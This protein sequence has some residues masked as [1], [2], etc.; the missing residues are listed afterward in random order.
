MDMQMPDHPTEAA[1]PSPACMTAFLKILAATMPH[2]E[3]EAPEDTNQRWIAMR[4]SFVAFNP[5]DA[6]E[7]QLAALAVAAAQ[8]SA[9]G[10]AR[11]NRPGTGFET[12]ARNRGS[13]LA[14]F[15]AYFQVFRYFKSRD[16]AEAAAAA[17]LPPPHHVANPEPEPE[18]EAPRREIPRLPQFQPRDRYGNP[19]KLWRFQDM[20]KKQVDATYGDPFDKSLWAAAI[21][22]EEIAIAEQKAMDEAAAAANSPPPLAGSGH[23]PDQG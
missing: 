6:A 12:A 20:T 13:A 15:R 1:G 18:P 17:D 3:G 2:I 21:E 7:A 22:E 9:D 23:E 14:N 5:H 19:I 4:D 10:Y 16:Q 11:A 8:A